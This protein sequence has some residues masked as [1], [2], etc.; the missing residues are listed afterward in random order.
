M[1]ELIEKFKKEHSLIIET[2]N[3]VKAHGINTEDGI[4]ELLSAKDNI[5]AH[6]KKEDEEFYPKL[7]KEAESNQRLKELLDAFDKDMDEITRYSIEFFDDYT[8]ATRSELALELEKFIA[9]LE[10]RTLREETFLFAEFEK[11]HK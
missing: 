2:L 6:M 8:T 10:R 5:T 1:S 11:L 7:R 3:R 9:I 4:E